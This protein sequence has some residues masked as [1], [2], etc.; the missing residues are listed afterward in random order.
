MRINLLLLVFIT[1]FSINTFAQEHEKEKKNLLTVALGYTY[2]PKASTLDAEEA[3][4]IFVPTIGLD[5]FRRLHPR[6]EIGIMAD[7]ELGEY[8][9]F[10]KEL[11]RENAVLLT[12]MVNF[13]LSKHI[14]FLA[15][16]GME[17]E[18]HKN[19]GI[20]RLGGEY[21]FKLPKNW[22]IAPGVFF[23]FKE[24]TDT[25]SLSVAIGKEF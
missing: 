6:W 9:V 10:E 11:N 7:I 24:G 2:I 21:V 16:G 23:D 15:G 18:K 17:F 25:W 1:I 12:A 20:I 3:T 5:Y 4:G 19:L 14:N 8:V 13:N 22:V